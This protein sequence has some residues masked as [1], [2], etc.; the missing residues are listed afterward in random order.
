MIPHQSQELITVTDIVHF[1]GFS[2]KH[3]IKSLFCAP[4]LRQQQICCTSTDRILSPL[5]SELTGG[6]GGGSG[7]E[8]LCFVLFFVNKSGFKFA[9]FFTVE[10]RATLI[11]LWT[12]KIRCELADR[13]LLKVF[14]LFLRTLDGFQLQ[15]EPSWYRSCRFNLPLCNNVESSTS[16]LLLLLILQQFFCC[17]SKIHTRSGVLG[18]VV[19]GP[20]QQICSEQLPYCFWL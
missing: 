12:V 14:P 5:T 11:P 18:V 4:S 7:G 6:S 16:V 13:C 15:K 10:I 20:R 19:T 9:F 8:M 17:I 2:L 3:K 1:R